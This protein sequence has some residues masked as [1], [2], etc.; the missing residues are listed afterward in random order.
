MACTGWPVDDLMR[1]GPTRAK[2]SASRASPC[3]W[4]DIRSAVTGR[5]APSIPTAV[6][7]IALTATAVTGSCPHCRFTSRMPSRAA[8][9]LLHTRT[10]PSGSGAA[11]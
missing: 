4:C 1:S 7:P 5:P 9:D 2:I 11:R 8:S 6:S 10:P 3:R